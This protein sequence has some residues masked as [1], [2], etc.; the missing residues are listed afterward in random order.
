[1]MTYMIR[2]IREGVANLHDEKVL[3]MTELPTPIKITYMF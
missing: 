2:R 3:A 1:M